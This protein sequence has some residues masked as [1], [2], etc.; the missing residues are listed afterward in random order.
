MGRMTGLNPKGIKGNVNIF[1]RVRSLVQAGGIH[2]PRWL[3]AMFVY[4]P[5]TDPQIHRSKIPELTYEEDQFREWYTLRFDENP[6]VEAD[7]AQGYLKGLNINPRERFVQKCVKIMKNEGVEP[8]EAFERAT[9]E[10]V[11]ARRRRDFEHQVFYRQALSR[12]FTRNK[13][14]PATLA[15]DYRMT[16]VVDTIKRAQMRHAEKVEEARLDREARQQP[17]LDNVREAY[18]K[19]SDAEKQEVVRLVKEILPRLV[20]ALQKPDENMQRRLRNAAR[21]DATDVYKT[22]QAKS[23]P[24]LQ[25]GDKYENWQQ[26]TPTIGSWEPAQ[27]PIQGQIDKQKAVLQFEEKAMVYKWREVERDLLD[28]MHQVLDKDTKAKL[29]DEKLRELMFDLAKIRHRP[30]DVLATEL[31]NSKFFRLATRYTEDDPNT[32][33]HLNGTSRYELEWEAGEEQADF[34]KNNPRK[35]PMAVDHKMSLWRH[36]TQR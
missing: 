20:E 1:N 21:M 8:I 30:Y 25:P 19:F 18:H 28:T 17:L 9:K 15:Q 22:G 31:R 10:S 29:D 3:D 34:W 6:A 36:W 27:P 5:R 24:L 7:M 35:H 14:N 32:A 23:L 16:H 11:D 13:W 2:K 33:H 4:R 26:E 12:G